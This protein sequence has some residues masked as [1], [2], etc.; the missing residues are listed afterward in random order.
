MFGDGFFAY[1]RP[2]Y[3]TNFAELGADFVTLA[4]NNIHG[5]TI[6]LTDRA[7]SAAATSG[8]RFVQDHFTMLE[9]YVL[10]TL[11]TAATW[12][13]CIDA[14]AAINATLGETGWTI[15]SEKVLD[16][17]TDDSLASALNYAPFNINPSLWTSTTRGDD[18]T[19]DRRYVNPGSAFGNSA[20]TA[21]FTWIYV[22]RMP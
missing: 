2:V 7:G 12:N 22:R 6:R 18:T 4:A 5:N 10:G 20:K 1:T 9:W 19:F 17:I 21:T 11:P 16:T 15:P 8:N 13:N 14:G 3:P